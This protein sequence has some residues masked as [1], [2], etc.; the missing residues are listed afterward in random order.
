MSEVRHK[1]SHLPVALAVTA[2]VVVGAGL[3]IVVGGSDRLELH[4]TGL[5]A[6]PRDQFTITQPLLM[7]GVPGLRI[8]RG[9]ISLSERHTSKSMT[10]EAEAAL[11]AGGHARLLLD[12]GAIVI[13]RSVLVRTEPSNPGLAPLAAA[14]S[15]GNFETLTVQRTMLSYL[16]QDGRQE[17]V[18]EF[19]GEIV[20][21]RRTS[22]TA[23]GTVTVRGHKV[24]IDA[25]LGLPPA[26]DKRTATATA[27][28]ARQQ[29]KAYIKGPMLEAS[30]D[31]RLAPADVA[32]LQGQG[33]LTVRNLRDTA[34]WIGLGWPSGPGL[35][36]F[37]IKG[38]V[39][40]SN[41]ALAFQRATM[42]M[43]GN[44]STG[45]LSVDFSASRP[46]FSAT[47]AMQSLDLSRYVKG[48]RGDAARCLIEDV[49][50]PGPFAL[51]LV[52]YLNADVR[53]LANRVRTGSFDL[54][55]SA[56]TLTLKNGKLLADLA[57]VAIEDAR[58][59]GQL[60]V[61]MSDA[62]P[63]YVLRGKVAG[64][65]L[66]RINPDTLTGAL[67]LQGRGDLV[68]DVSA[69]GDTQLDLL[70]TL[71]GKIGLAM[72]TGGRVGLDLKS[73]LSAA[74][75]QPL[76]GWGANA[77]GS[78]SVD[79]LQG[80]IIV[81]EGVVF[82]ASFSAALGDSQLT[83]SG[84]GNL[85]NGLVDLRLSMASRSAERGG[86]PSAVGQPVDAL[87]LRGPWNE[88]QIRAERPSTAVPAAAAIS[89]PAR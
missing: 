23:R 44:E 39:E 15:D 11:L 79:S 83:A 45:T 73:L 38:A 76:L 4:G 50:A 12:G 86:G 9:A 20:L 63:R 33:E 14:L 41:N 51:P 7:Q 42:Q 18:G 59:S 88:P 21:K 89:A 75:K 68:A 47:L 80:R 35:A 34:R 32:P 72:P 40:W 10:G 5:V 62:E 65:D 82:T 70:R 56:A 43:D 81:S 27:S 58:G 1:A 8:E 55:Q 84:G 30:F 16:G 57:E 26:S 49:W 67:P 78:T 24:A 31:G 69:T 71:S 61:D 48:W 36:D 28:V 52:R 37:K 74:Q 85:R 17:I 22:M 87:I 13:D 19:N 25:T 2:L 46:S 6:A 54:G 64:L 66:G 29:L 77:R 60:T 53:I 3:P